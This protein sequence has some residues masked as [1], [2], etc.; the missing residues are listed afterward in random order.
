MKKLIILILTICLA[1]MLVA[2]KHEPEPPKTPKQV[3]VCDDMTWQNTFANEYLSTLRSSNVNARYELS[4]VST[5]D[6]DEYRDAIDE[7]DVTLKVWTYDA[8]NE[9]WLETPVTY[10]GKATAEPYYKELEKTEELWHLCR[11]RMISLDFTA[12]DDPWY[13]STVNV[14]DGVFDLILKANYRTRENAY[15]FKPVDHEL[16]NIPEGLKGSASGTNIY[17]VCR[18]LTG[19]AILSFEV[20]NFSNKAPS[21][22]IGTGD[23]SADKRNW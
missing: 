5:K 16:G 20:T 22:L 21:A 9:K 3:Q 8:I 13:Q 18:E 4:F 11:V 23:W 10:T 6:F 19:D 15:A 2:C 12:V 14:Y 17:S 1:G 7:A